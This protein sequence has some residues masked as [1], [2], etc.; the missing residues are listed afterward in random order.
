MN[1]YGIPEIFES[2][3]EGIIKDVYKDIQYVLKVPIVNFIFR[4]LAN[5]P[6]FLSDAWFQV[7]PNMLTARIEVAAET[8]RY[9]DILVPVPAFHSNTAFNLYTQQHYIKNIVATFQYV[10]PKLLLIASAWSES[11]SNRPIEPKIISNEFIQP[12]LFDQMPKIEL[13][14]IP[15]AAPSVRNVL[16]DIAKEHHSFDV[17]S[18]YRALATIPGLLEKVWPALKTFIGTEEYTLLQNRLLKKSIMLVHQEMPFPI[19]FNR[20]RLESK[21]SSAHIAGIMSLVS[22]F[23]NFLPGLILEIEFIRRMLNPL[24]YHFKDDPHSLTQL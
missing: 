7:R 21:Y 19:S 16:L 1:G 4:A 20:K 24:D 5:Y 11:L 15:K 22:Y 3:A 8:L 9:P 6:E 14:H 23:Q 10:N 12:G 13:E 17:A 18:D 2:E